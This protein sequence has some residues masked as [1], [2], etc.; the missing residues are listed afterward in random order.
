[1]SSDQRVVTAPASSWIYPA[2]GQPTPPGGAKVLL[3]TIGSVAVIGSWTSD[4]RYL[5]WA[6]LPKR[7]RQLEVEK[8]IAP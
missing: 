1:M 5:A 6:P 7:N 8:G 4:G 3:L 2:A